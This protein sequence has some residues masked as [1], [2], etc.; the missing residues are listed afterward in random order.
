MSS[1]MGKDNR[2]EEK[3]DAESRESEKFKKRDSGACV[4]C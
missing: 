2:C 4:F 3:G 1:K